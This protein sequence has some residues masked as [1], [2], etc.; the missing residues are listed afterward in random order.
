MAAIRRRSQAL[1]H[2]PGPKYNLITGALDLLGRKDL[3]RALHELAEKHGPIVK[4]RIL[5]KHVMP[6]LFTISQSEC[7]LSQKLIRHLQ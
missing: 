4:F 2:L 3:H 5:N 1:K 6:M 7:L